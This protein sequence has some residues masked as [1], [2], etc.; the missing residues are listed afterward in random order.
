M[1][2]LAAAITSVGAT[3]IAF[4][5]DTSVFPNP[6]RGFY[7]YQNLASLSDE[8][9]KMREENL[10]LLWGKI[11]LEPYR[12]T[13]ELPASFLAKLQTGF[14]SAQTAGVKVIVRASYGHRGPGGDYTTYED[15][16]TAIIR[17]HLKQLRPL[18]ERNAD[19]IA[20]FE[21]GFIGPWGEWHSTTLAND[22]I[23]RRDLFMQLLESTPKNRM[24]VVR[25]PALKQSF[26]ESAEPLTLTQ[27][28]TGSHQART[29]HHNDC[30]LSSTNDVGTYNR[31]GLTMAQEQ[32]YLAADTLHTLF[33]GETCATHVRSL[34][35][36][37]IPE[38][39]K[40]HAS[41]LNS[42]YHPDVLKR[43]EDLDIMETISKRLGAR[44]V[45]ESLVLPDKGTPGAKIPL[46][47]T[48]TNHGF[49]SLYN[50]RPVHLILRSESGQSIHRFP[51]DVDPRHWKPA[52]CTRFAASVTLPEN[53]APGTYTWHLHLP[54]ASARLASDPRFAYRFA[55]RDLWNPET[56]EHQLVSEW[57][58][59]P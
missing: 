47:F 58:V 34:P 59:A 1:V 52:V 32:T 46:A 45:L 8:V 54:D 33:G 31:E 7:L 21:A 26:F 39:E 14:E 2:I 42:A 20:F 57:T 28:Y 4:E 56:G 10:T 44:F 22:V 55:N 15:P 36:T 29:G 27:A 9:N 43:W 24:V 17:G 51:L 5:E 50:E 11:D 41:Y 38:M 12:T 19:R 3:E 16:A 13:A 53:L 18:F 30:F 37:A 25:Y 48:L 49:A 40:L 23:A 6:D 35:N